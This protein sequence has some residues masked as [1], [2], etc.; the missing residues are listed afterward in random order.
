MLILDSREQS[1]GKSAEAM[2]LMMTTFA[3]KG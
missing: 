1:T 2:A 3:Y